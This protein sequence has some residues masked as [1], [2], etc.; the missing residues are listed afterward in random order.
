MKKVFFA[1]LGLAFM[2]VSCKKS[3]PAPTPTPT[4]T[5]VTPSTP[6]PFMTVTP[7]TTWRFQ[8]HDNTSGIDTNYT[9]TSTTADLQI[10]SKL[11]HV[12]SDSNETTNQLD[13]QYYNIT[14][15]D[16]YQYA[17]LGD[18]LPSFTL[19]YLN[20]DKAVGQTVGDTTISTSFNLMNYPVSVTARIV[21]TIE[22]KSG[23]Y[24]IN[25]INYDSVIKVKTEIPTLTAS[26]TISFP[27]LPPQTI[28]IPI[29]HTENIHSYYAPRVG[30][31][32]RE[33]SIQATADLRT[34]QSFLTTLPASIEL[35]N[36]NKTTTLLSSSIQ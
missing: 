29:T 17:T 10:N 5:P 7:G 24:P 3:D 18:P 4:P 31:I 33:Y 2:G 26:V 8:Q 19:K 6:S 22:E 11:F 30:Q 1:C 35:I 15:N 27:P 21:T 25:S 16:Y 9:M 12:F 34:L 28:N 32:K 13:S 14:G 20:T 23:T 36:T